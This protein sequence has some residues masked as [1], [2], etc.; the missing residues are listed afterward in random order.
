MPE[1]AWDRFHIVRAQPKK[2]KRIVGVVKISPLGKAS[3]QQNLVA[4]TCQRLTG[5]W[6]K[7]TPTAALEPGEYAV[8]ELLGMQGMNTYVWD[9][10][11]NPSA[12]ANAGSL[13]SDPQSTATPPDK[14]KDQQK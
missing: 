8:V 13:H 7:L 10:G 14:P 3:Q 2:G 11:V 6:V 4:T 9:F 12:P 1:L 5:G